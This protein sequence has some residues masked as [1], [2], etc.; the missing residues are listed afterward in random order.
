MDKQ[1]QDSARHLGTHSSQRSVFKEQ[2][3]PALG[4]MARWENKASGQLPN[5]KH[6]YGDHRKDSR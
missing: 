3:V 5:R 2:W 6:I 4:V 1:E